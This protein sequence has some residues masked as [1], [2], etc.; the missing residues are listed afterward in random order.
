MPLLYGEGEKAFIRLQEEI[1][2]QSA[3][4]SILAWAPKLDEIGGCFV[5]SPAE[6]SEVA[7]I[8]SLH[9]KV[10][11]WTMT[12]IGLTARLPILAVTWESTEYLAVL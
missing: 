3:D 12:N 7:D 5:S 8:E 9:T 11:T 4:Q 1:I 6:F 2:K 10:K